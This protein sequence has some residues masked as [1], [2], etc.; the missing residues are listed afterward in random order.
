RDPCSPKAAHVVASF[1]P[2][3]TKPELCMAAWSKAFRLQPAERQVAVGLAQ[4]CSECGSY[5]YGVSAMEKSR[6]YGEI[7]SCNESLMLSWLYLLTGR[8]DDAVIEYRCARMMEPDAPELAELS[9]ALS[10]A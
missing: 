5:V 10:E 4:A 3:E 2:D 8:R 1:L 9:Q 6:C 7:P